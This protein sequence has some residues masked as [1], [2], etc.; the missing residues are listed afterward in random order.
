MFSG[1]HKPFLPEQGTFLTKRHWIFSQNARMRAIYT[2]I[3]R[4]ATPRSAGG[5]HPGLDKKI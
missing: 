5:R 2:P 4:V 1:K 3:R